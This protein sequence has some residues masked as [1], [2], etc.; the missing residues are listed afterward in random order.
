M[1]SCFLDLMN[2]QNPV[3]RQVCD[4]GLGLI[5]EI[6]DKWKERIKNERFSS[7]NAQWLEAVARTNLFKSTGMT[8]NTLISLIRNTDGSN[9][10]SSRR[11]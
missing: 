8:I 11:S 4:A 3:V 6:D 1:A 5:C 2:D 9:I 10:N 7:H